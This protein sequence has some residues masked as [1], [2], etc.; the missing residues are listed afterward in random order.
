M[1]FNPTIVNVCHR[2]AHSIPFFLPHHKDY[3]GFKHLATAS[4]GLFLD[5]G[6]N[7]GI[8]ALGFRQINSN[9]HILSIEPNKIHEQSLRDIARRLQR[10]DYKIIGAGSKKGKKILYIPYAGRTPMDTLASLNR[11]LVQHTS[12]FYA[13]AGNITYT[14]Q[15]VNI[16]P[17][18]SL[19]LHPDIIKI[20]TE[21]YELDV[22]RGL[23]QTI[24][25]YRP[26]ILI[27]STPKL[28]AGGNKFFRARS[29]SLFTYDYRTD[30]F[31]PCIKNGAPEKNH[32]SKHLSNIFCIP[33]EKIHLLP[34][35]Y[36]AQKKRSG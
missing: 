4:H 19:N 9:Y 2:I 14:R 25:K 18:D 31:S 30:L 35:P 13:H 16:I 22:L 21:G 33:K 28:L 32:D 15:A 1:R 26:Y 23:I 12:T 11:T 27:E 3:Y 34:M 17:L 10:F 29:Y 7:D 6:A 8:S 36:P 5:V 20:D 24:R